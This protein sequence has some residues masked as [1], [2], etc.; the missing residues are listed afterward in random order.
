LFVFGEHAEEALNEEV[1]DFLPFFAS[2]AHGF[3]EAGELAGGLGGDRRG[4]LLGAQFFRVGEHP[5]ERLP[6]FRLN[7]LFDADFTRFVRVAGEG[8]VNDDASRSQTTSSGGLSSCR[9]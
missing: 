4:R 1:G 2:G 3:G 5:F 7:Q 8:G 9:A 6:G